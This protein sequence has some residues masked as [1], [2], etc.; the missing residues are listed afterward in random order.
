MPPIVAQLYMGTL[1][2]PHFQQNLTQKE[3]NRDLIPSQWWEST[4]C[5]KPAGNSIGWHLQCLQTKQ[6]LSSQLYLATLLCPHSQKNL[7]EKEL[8]QDLIL[9]TVCGASGKY[10]KELA[11]EWIPHVRAA[12]MV[13][14]D[15]E[16]K[17]N[18]ILINFC[19]HSLPRIG[20][21]SG[22]WISLAEVAK[23]AQAFMIK[24]D[25]LDI[26]V[27]QMFFLAP[28]PRSKDLWGC[29]LGFKRN[30]CGDDVFPEAWMPGQKQQVV[31][32]QGLEPAVSVSLAASVLSWSKILLNF[33]FI[34]NSKMK[35]WGIGRRCSKDPI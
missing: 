4:I 14:K 10:A 24:V 2:W 5:L 28:L 16:L 20:W 33:Q 29:L 19:I 12:W 25:M 21:A 9:S 17:Q 3:L 18:L 26:P 23:M 32:K 1:L 27:G 8:N 11:L 35:N 22:T 15:K 34:C 6:C 31:T 30:W 7:M 13:A